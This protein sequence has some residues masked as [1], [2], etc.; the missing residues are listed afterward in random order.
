M[1]G[2]GAV[3]KKGIPTAKAKIALSNS[4]PLALLKKKHE[5]D[6]SMS[7]SGHSNCSGNSADS[8]GTTKE[9]RDGG[10]QQA[11]TSAS[12]PGGSGLD[13]TRKRRTSLHMVDGKIVPT[14]VG[15]VAGTS[16]LII[17]QM[18]FAEALAQAA[19]LPV[20]DKGKD[21]SD[22]GRRRSMRPSMDKAPLPVQ[23]TPVP[24]DASPDAT[25]FRTAA[26]SGTATA[27]QPTRRRTFGGQ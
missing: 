15:D 3:E 26:V 2:A 13:S 7:I 22:H 16:A 17:S 12:K 25:T 14:I 20:K 1:I 24:V 8:K 18:Q 9:S 11:R 19:T 6:N 5:S 27:K 4:G 21:R 10:E 23:L